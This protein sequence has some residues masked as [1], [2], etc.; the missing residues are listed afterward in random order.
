MTRVCG[1]SMTRV[2]GETRISTHDTPREATREAAGH[3]CEQ[4]LAPACPAGQAG[5]VRN[6]VGMESKQD[7][8]SGKAKAE[9]V[10]LSTQEESVTLS[11]QEA[12]SFDFKRA[13]QEKEVAAHFSVAPSSFH[14]PL[15]F[16]LLCPAPL[17]QSTLHTLPSSP[18]SPSLPH[19]FSHP[20][21]SHTPCRRCLRFGDVGSEC[22]SRAE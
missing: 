20:H 16:L 19:P 9:S 11:T 2:C 4:A 6:D 13:G 21:L 10:T 12:A 5:S 15:T 22:D 1:E 18:S 7:A 8:R 17:P 14:P 3:D